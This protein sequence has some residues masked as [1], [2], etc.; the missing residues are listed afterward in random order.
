MQD[1]DKFLVETH[2][3]QPASLLGQ[4]HLTHVNP[5]GAYL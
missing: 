4:K 1:K 3:E 5:Y 2:I